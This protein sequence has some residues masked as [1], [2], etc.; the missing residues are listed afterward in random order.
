MDEPR[1]EIMSTKFNAA[2]ARFDV[3]NAEDPDGEELLYAQRM[4]EWLGKFA[5]DASE[6]VKLAARSQHI[7]R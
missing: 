2:I 5:P 6:T 4:S 7:R 3:A 1:L